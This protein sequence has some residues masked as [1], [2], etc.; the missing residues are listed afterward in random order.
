M[1]TRIQP[2]DALELL[3]DFIGHV[4]SNDASAPAENSADLPLLNASQPPTSTLKKRKISDVA[5]PSTEI[6]RRRKWTP[7]E[8]AQIVNAHLEGGQRNMQIV[9]NN[10]GMS[11]SLACKIVSEFKNPERGGAETLFDHRYNSK[12][13]YNLKV[14]MKVEQL[15]E[16]M[17]HDE[18]D[19]TLE[20]LLCFA[21]KEILR[22]LLLDSNVYLPTEERLPRGMLRPIDSYEHSFSS[23]EDYKSLTERFS[24]QKLNSMMTIR[25]VFNRR[26][27]THKRLIY[28]KST[29]NTPE[30]M[31]KRLSYCNSI[32]KALLDS[33][34]FFIF[35]DEMP[36]YGGHGRNYGWAP[37]GKRSVKK[38]YPQSQFP[39]KTTVVQ[40]VTKEGGLIAY[41]VHPPTKQVIVRK[42]KAKK[43]SQTTSQASV[44]CASVT[45]STKTEGESSVSIWVPSYDAMKYWGFIDMLLSTLASEYRCSL[46]GK[47]IM[48]IV[49]SDPSH[50]S[51]EDSTARLRRL[52]HYTDVKN[53][54][55]LD[56]DVFVVHMPANS[57][58][59][60]LAE[61]YNRQL[62]GLVNKMDR[63]DDVR[64]V[65]FA[66]IFR[67]ENLQHRLEVMRECIECSL[68]EM[69]AAPPHEQSFNTLIAFFTKVIQDN[70]YLD[71][72]Q[73]M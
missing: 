11:I 40:A 48:L 65:K 38:G 33:N 16:E 39:H 63:S 58:Q 25:R 49:D 70:G 69:K 31:A 59:L 3:K 60:N 26:L 61:Y 23:A 12:R 64:A 2:I 51:R 57:P 73:K 8:K 35:L 54:V 10:L 30:N 29:V 24:K 56:K 42:K 67:G 9:A 43:A 66:S 47:N 28:E 6:K 5:T 41:Q 44:P 1:N 4:E 36:F 32:L 19:L 46:P 17:V 27:L 50:G 7:K 20:E 45:S 18:P 62:R 37:K 15:L 55:G 72:H 21:N 53:I 71:Y 68:S 34:S 22:Q 13:V 14:P 52:D